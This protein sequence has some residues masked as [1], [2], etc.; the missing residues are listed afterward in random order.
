MTRRALGLCMALA[1]EGLVPIF[2]GAA[3]TTAI[4]LEL[5]RRKRPT[6]PEA[7]APAA[8]APAEL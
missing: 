6:R 2:I 5:K 4:Q 3:E 7:E 1:E 8:Q